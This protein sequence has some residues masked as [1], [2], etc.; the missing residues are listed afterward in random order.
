M[1]QYESYKAFLTDLLAGSKD[2]NSIADACNNYCS[3]PGHN[4]K[5]CPVAS[6]MCCPTVENMKGRKS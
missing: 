1:K 4:C 3:K 2:A 6:F 5:E